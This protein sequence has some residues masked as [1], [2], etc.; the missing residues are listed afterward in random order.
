MPISGGRLAS[1]DIVRGY[2]ILSMVLAHLGSGGVLFAVTHIHPGF[3]GAS[4]FVLLSGL[5]LGIV[6]HRRLR[7]AGLRAV[8]VRTLRRL[9]LLYV[10]QF[11][12][13]LL[14]VLVVQ[15]DRLVSPDTT[16]EVV[17][18]LVTMQIAPSVGNILRM[19]VVFFCLALPAY[20]MLSRG[21]AALLLCCSFA[22][23]VLGAFVAPEY[24]TFTR[25]LTNAE[26]YSW[27]GWQLLFFS[28][29]VVGWYWESHDLLGRLQRHAWP[30]LG[31][32]AGVLVVTRIGY[33]WVPSWFDKGTFAPARILV[34]YGAVAFLVV[35]VE[36]LLARVPRPLFRPLE[37]TGRRSL[38]SYLIHAAIGI[39]AVAGLGLP[40]GDLLA[41]TAFAVCWGW[42]ELREK[43]HAV[44]QRGLSATDAGS[45]AGRRPSPAWTRPVRAGRPPARPSDPPC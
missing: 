39:V 21:R 33:H 20:W 10:A 19:Y 14:A 40:R 15:R 7:T 38:D 11:A 28:A 30:V 34:A 31:I 8:E 13:S 41:F 45:S 42:A 5:V 17:L 18:G 24:T 9:G 25:D 37:S 12:I 35:L 1:I 27:A 4:G 16:G 6:Q 26:G 23:Y 22:L 29:L 3:D 32:A 36:L 44:R 2:S 43:V